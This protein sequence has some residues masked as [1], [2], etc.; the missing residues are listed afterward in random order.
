MQ[1]VDPQILQ[2]INAAKAAAFDAHKMH[3]HL[4][5][6][7]SQHLQELLSLT[8]QQ[9]DNID[10]AFAKLKQFIAANTAEPAPK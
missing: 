9:A 10:D 7:V 4:A 1:S 6:V 8:H 3:Q 5:S 2:E